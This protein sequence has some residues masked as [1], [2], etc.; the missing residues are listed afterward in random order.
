MKRHKDI[1]TY[2][3]SALALAI[4]MM[5]WA[6]PAFA[7]QAPASDD[8]EDAA[9]II[10]TGTSI[11]GVAPTGANLISVDAKALEAT[12][13]QTVSDALRTVPS[14]SNAGATGQ[15]PT[16]AFYQ[17]SI[18][19]LGASASNSTLVLI[20]G[21]RGPTGGTNHTFLDP[22]I[23]PP[24]MLERVEVLPEGASSIYGS[25]AVAGVVN[26]ITR[27]RFDGLRMNG[28]FV[29]TDGTHG[30]SAGLMAGKTWDTGSAV[31]AYNHSF[32]GALAARDRP[33]TYPDQSDRGGTSF[34][35][36]NCG[37]ATLQP[38]GS[39]PIYTSAT[40]GVS[41]T[42]TPAN[43]PCTNWNYSD[44]IG[45]EDRHQVMGKITLDMTDD[46][47]VGLDMVYARRRNETIQSAGTLQATAFRTG[48]QGNPFFTVPAGYAGTSNSQTIRWDATDLVG[49]ARGFTGSDSMYASFTAN[50]RITENWDFDFLAS[51][52]RDES[53]SWSEGMINGSVANLALNG[54]TNGG[55]N[56][57]AISIPGT[58]VIV[59][60]L[61]LTAANALDVWNP[62]ASNR[63]SQAVRDRLLDNENLLRNTSGY[64][65]VRGSISGSLLELPAGPIKLAIGGELY[66][67]Q[68]SQFVTRAN[69]SGPA[70][71]GSQQLLFKFDREVYSA[72]GELNVPVISAEM[73]VPLVQKLDLSVA[74]RYD[75]Y[76]DFGSTSNPKFAF[77]WEVNDSLRFRGNYSTSFV[78]PPL[79][80]VGDRFGAFGTAG[81]NSVTNNLVV[82]IA[83]YPDLALMGIPGCNATSTTC[84]IASLEGIQVTSSDLDVGAQDGSGWSLGFDFKPE[85]LPGFRAS[86]TFWDT[87]FTGGITGPNI[88]NV[89][90]TA[91]ANFLL[92]FYPGGATPAQIAQFTNGI[93]QRSSLPGTTSYIFRSLGGNWLNLSIQGIDYSIDYVHQT[94]NLGTF[95]LGVVGT[96]FLKFTQSFGSGESYDI[97]NTT[98]NNTTFPSIAT[99]I[100][101]TLGWQNDSLSV[102]L[103][104][105]YTGNYTNWSGNSVTPITRDP[106]GNPSGGGDKVDANLTFDANFVYTIPENGILSGA[107]LS[108]SGR[109]IFDKKP[110][111][112][113]GTN[114][115]DPLAGNPFGRTITFGL[116]FD[117]F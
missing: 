105:N 109:N 5:V 110:P 30:Y 91:S 54:T 60:N 37:P 35:N 41:V 65:Q 16:V 51:A 64:Q 74:G 27:K 3:G 52:G 58:D 73:G 9:D 81:W 70:S 33:F 86:G 28:Q 39:G 8:S 26:F 10:V 72:F 67:T 112:Y 104:A 46:L 40:S 43:A 62:G 23:I 97:L 56:M 87:K 42:N 13:S 107:Q 50:Y 71:S 55:G 18:H 38:G 15:G 83:A 79:T 114:G 88:G 68:L 7:Q 44:L 95:H 11:R 12:G 57:N 103:F 108:I 36:F 84:N 24:M 69:N 117:L 102:D 82:P 96:E 14:L 113:N 17:P 80:V 31:F 76:S 115:Y 100:R 49:P 116:R 34:L 85:F 111:F 25:D 2:T 1:T 53:S 45:S 90:N 98:G 21:H 92:N 20:D 22:N 75:H 29:V 94:E 61:P 77:G 101:G 106:I 78:A 47:T 89:V 99:Q 4:G 59:L 32:Q 19:N 66:R 6:A 63:T 93:P 48:A